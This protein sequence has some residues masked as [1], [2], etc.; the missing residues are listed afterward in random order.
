MDE[1]LI[2]LEER[3]Q[4]LQEA[5]RQALT[6]HDTC[7]VR[8]LGAELTRAQHAWDVLCGLSGAP[9]AVRPESAPTVIEP[10]RDAPLRDRAPHMLLFANTWSK[11]GSP[12]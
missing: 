9:D 11:T 1:H 3:M 2:A 7:Q 4:Q 5:V 10:H 8:L 12:E 6:Q